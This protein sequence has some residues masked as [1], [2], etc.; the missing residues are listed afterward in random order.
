MSVTGSV[1]RDLGRN[2]LIPSNL[3]LQGVIDSLPLRHSL[4][5][6]RTKQ[7][8]DAVDDYNNALVLQPVNMEAI[9][10][11]SL[12]FETAG[13]LEMAEAVLKNLAPAG[14]ANIG[15]PPA[16]I[17]A[18]ADVPAESHAVSDAAYR[19]CAFYYR[20]QP[21]TAEYLGK[22]EEQCALGYRL[23]PLVFRNVVFQAEVVEQRF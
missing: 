21:F 14:L 1:F 8:A 16:T 3:A 6:F 19:T 12:V 18:R 4:V 20:N 11:L 15:R 10:N 22:A 7:F 23:D 9:L 17:L 5:L 2:S 13:D